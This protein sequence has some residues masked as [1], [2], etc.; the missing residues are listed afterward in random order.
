MD[1]VESETE[2][3][4]GTLVMMQQQLNLARTTIE[5]LAVALEATEELSGINGGSVCASLFAKSKWPLPDSLAH[6][7]VKSSPSP[8]LPADDDN[9]SPKQ[10]EDATTLL[11]EVPPSKIAKIESPTI[12]FSKEEAE[13]QAFEEDFSSS[14]EVP[15][16]KVKELD[17][18][19]DVEVVEEEEQLVSTS[20]L[21]AEL[22][23]ASCFTP[24]PPPILPP[25][26]PSIVPS[27]HRSNP[28]CR[29]PRI[30]RHLT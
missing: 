15:C 28:I 19:P 8:S 20:S 21:E 18:L 5:V 4:T 24:S 25:H 23:N 17:P 11:A 22:S 14:S 29:D 2:V 27:P 9:V 30:L 6:L 26:A 12:E 10:E 1:E 16:L 13:E 7:T 3:F